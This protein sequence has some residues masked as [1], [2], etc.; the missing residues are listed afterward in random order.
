M[1]IIHINPK[2]IS[3]LGCHWGQKDKKMGEN[4]VKNTKSQFFQYYD[5]IEAQKLHQMVYNLETIICFRYVG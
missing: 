3:S 2:K 1:Q 5:V 4:A